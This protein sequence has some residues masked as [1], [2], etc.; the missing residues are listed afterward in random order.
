MLSREGRVTCHKRTP[1]RRVG[2]L[3]LKIHESQAIKSQ[4]QPHAQKLKILAQLLKKQGLGSTWNGSVA[5]LRK[6]RK[7]A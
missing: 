2:N 6:L 1:Q 4:D 3:E 5:G 7:R